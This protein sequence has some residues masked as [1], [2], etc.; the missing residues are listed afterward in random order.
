MD[1]IKDGELIKCE[2][3]TFFK[4]ED[5]GIDYVIYTDNSLDDEDKKILY[6]ARYKRIDTDNI[7]LL[8]IENDEEWDIIDEV[9]GGIDSYEE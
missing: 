2:V 1:I 7:E 5:T 3:I 9:I 6:G 4:N 8:D